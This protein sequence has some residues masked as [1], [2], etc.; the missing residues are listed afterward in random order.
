QTRQA[1]RSCDQADRGIIDPLFNPYGCNVQSVFAIVASA[2]CLGLCWLAWRISDARPPIILSSCIINLVK[3]IVLDSMES[4]RIVLDW[5][6]PCL[7]N[8][9]GYKMENVDYVGIPDG[10]K[11]D[12]VHY[13]ILNDQLRIESMDYWCVF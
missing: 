7:M 6:R 11:M 10:Y 12:E 5:I 9:A 1:R 3:C 8:I 2:G 13:S 4:E